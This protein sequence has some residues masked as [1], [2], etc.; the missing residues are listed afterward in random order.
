MEL[1]AIFE[2]KTKRAFFDRAFTEWYDRTREQLR[3]LREEPK[4]FEYTGQPRTRA[5]A[6]AIKKLQGSEAIAQDPVDVVQK[7]RAAVSKTVGDLQG[8][9]EEHYEINNPYINMNAN[10]QLNSLPAKDQAVLFEHFNVVGQLSGQDSKVVNI[11]A[12]RKHRDLIGP[13][14]PQEQHQGLTPGA[15]MQ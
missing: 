15:K 3:V 12:G 2:D 13:Q 11:D 1:H 8:R 14:L 6:N 10:F 4:E 5:L 7:I 9:I